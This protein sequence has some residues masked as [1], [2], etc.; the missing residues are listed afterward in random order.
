MEAI[1]A[2]FFSFLRFY[3]FLFTVPSMRTYLRQSGILILALSLSL[4][5]INSSHLIDIANLTWMQA[6]FYAGRE[7]LLGFFMALPL[8]LAAQSLPLAGRIAD[9]SRGAQF[10][11]Q[12]LPGASRGV[13]PL[14]S[15]SVVA[16]PLLVFTFAGY[17]LVLNSIYESFTKYHVMSET[18]FEMPEISILILLSSKAIL[19]G[20]LFAAPTILCCFF[21]DVATVLITR[22][23][24]RI[25]LLFEMMPLK[26]ILGLIV[27]S[28]LALY[29]PRGISNLFFL[30]IETSSL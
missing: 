13:T 12:M 25:N 18:V 1:V 20:V 7:I 3:A 4:P 5:V 8:A 14:E 6:S 26:L 24:G 11:E 27:F 29:P 21:M 22:S 17:R 19:W 30:A 28:L 2:F 10:G 16:I 15:L 23:L 9:V